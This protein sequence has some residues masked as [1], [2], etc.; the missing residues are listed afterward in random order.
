MSDVDAAAAARLA[1]ARTRSVLVGTPIMRHPVWQYTLAYAETCVMLEQLGIRYSSRFVVGSSNLPRARNELA[2]RFLASGFTDLVLID[3]DMGWRANDVLRLV[4]S[5]QPVIAAV[6]RKKVDKPNSDPDVWCTYLENGP[7][8]QDAFGAVEV[9]YVGTGMMKIA[10]PVFEQMIAAH[11]EWKRPGTP[12]MADEVRQNYYQFF[13]FDPDD[14][15]EM[16]ED[17]CFCMRWRELGGRIWI[18]PAIELSHVGE[19]AYS[20]AI[21]EIMTAA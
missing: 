4:A 9:R 1:Y 16:G 8:V 13:R 12:D 20:G 6:G 3:D 17:F 2:A 7:L 11:P 5:E 10:R 21:S 15:F 18:D 19:K 14:R